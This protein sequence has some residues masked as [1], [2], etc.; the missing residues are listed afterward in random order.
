MRSELD[1]T[2]GPFLPS[3]GLIF[4]DRLAATPGAAQRR[5]D[6]VD[7]MIDLNAPAQEW[8]GRSDRQIALGPGFYRKNDDYSFRVDRNSSVG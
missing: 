8:R 4:D 7:P 3:V 1:S 2:K 6:E 5:L